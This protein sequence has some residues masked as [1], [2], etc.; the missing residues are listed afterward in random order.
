[1]P[2][3]FESLPIEARVP[4]PRERS[5]VVTIDWGLGLAEQADLLRTAG[6]YVDLAKIA[7][8]VSRLLDVDLLRDKI[9]LYRQHEV[10]AF[11]G[12]Q[13]L[14]Y[15][16]AQDA[17]DV[18]LEE[19]RESGYEAIEVSDN[20]IEISLSDKTALIARAVQEF[21][22]RV[23]GEAGKKEGM[24]HAV[25]LVDDARACLASGA[26]KVMLEAADV[27]P[28]GQEPQAAVER[29]LAQG[30]QPAEAIFELPGHWIP[31]TIY[32]DPPHIYRQLLAAVGPEVNVANIL[33]DRVIE[34]ETVRCGIGVNAA[35]GVRIRRQRQALRTEQ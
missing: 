20:L 32:A 14:E 33:P 25:S 16:L 8:G 35:H 5:L 3:G 31:G 11:P 28:T 27:F 19:A 6:E 1:M 4:K 10:V 30:L 21:G 26:W 24:S 17:E 18:F 9:A 12:G 2:K 29:L 34:Y 15:A 7:V 23:L 13:F 22:L